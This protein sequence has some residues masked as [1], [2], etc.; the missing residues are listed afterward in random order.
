M[1]QQIQL[2]DFYFIIMKRYFLI[3]FLFLFVLAGIGCNNKQG[4]NKESTSRNSSTLCF[5]SSDNKLND[6]FNWA[7]RQ[8]LAYA[9]ACDPAGLWYEAAL[10]GREA[11]C[12]RD[13]SHQAMGA[14]FL[15]LEDYTKNM[16]CHFARNIS[17]SRDWCSYW[18]INRYGNPA[19]VDYLDDN[20]FWYNLPANFD[21]LDCCYRMFMWSGDR[22]YLEDS[23]FNNFYE[24]TVYDYVE[25]WDLEPGTVMERPRLMNNRDELDT[26]RRFL[27]ARGIPGYNEGNQGYRVGIDLLATE[28]RAFISYS[29]LKQFAAEYDEALKF[30]LKAAEVADLI[31][32]VWWDDNMDTYY[33]HVNADGEMEGNVNEMIN[34]GTEHY[35]LYWKACTDT[36]RISKLLTM[37]A[38]NLP[39]GPIN[40]IEY[41][42]H[43][44]GILFNHGLN[45][46]AYDQLNYLYRA[47]RREY[48]EVSFTTVAAIVNGL[49]GVNIVA[50]T[51]DLAVTQG[52]YVDRYIMTL[53]GL[54]PS[55][56]WAEIKN[57]PVRANRITVRHDG[58]RR[59]SLTNDTGPSII[60][61]AC[62]PGSYEH[63]VVN[64]KKTEAYR[65]TYNSSTISWVRVIAGAGELMVVEVPD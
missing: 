6:I 31:E 36:A 5:S 37:L 56:E 57:V 28:Y 55:T 61:K 24:K 43:L 34:L 59:T 8:A 10:P 54:L 45:E 11:F 25:R 7:S 4:S 38:N 29:L 35:M 63:L 21:V 47:K 3:S 58:I 65:E 32:S 27:M 19:P 44:P 33:T 42:S 49:M 1:K 13:V 20:E 12:M 51:P 9:F 14:Y 16:L 53:P 22:Y 18:E 39:A 2:P 40:L 48:P 17:E 62:F 15:G 64:G 50:N 30:K 26:N 46:Q 23:V 60:W 52:H 41:Q